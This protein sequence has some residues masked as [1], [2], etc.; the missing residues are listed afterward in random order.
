M[1][2]VANLTL[3]ELAIAIG[4]VS[5]DRPS[6]GTLSAI[7]SGTRGASDEIL[8]SMEQVY[9]LEPNTITTAYRPRITPRGGAS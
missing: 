3:D 5:G 6:R 9:G 7:E 8:R 4:E 2:V 1:R